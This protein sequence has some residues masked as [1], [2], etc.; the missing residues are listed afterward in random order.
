VV[1]RREAKVQAAR[2]HSMAGIASWEESRAKQGEQNK[3]EQAH[4]AEHEQASKQAARGSQSCSL[5]FPGP[6]VILPQCSSLLTPGRK[7]QRNCKDHPSQANVDCSVNW[8][9]GTNASVRARHSA[10]LLLNT[11]TTSNT[12]DMH[13]RQ[14]TCGTSVEFTQL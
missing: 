5:H 6:L 3:A 13:L 12:R 7:H 9:P 4:H 2:C 11:T 10:I 14:R 8:S 1:C